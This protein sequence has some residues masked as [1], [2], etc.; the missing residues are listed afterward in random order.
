MKAI[1]TKANIFSVIF[2]MANLLFVSNSSSKEIFN[3]SI[4]NKISKSHIFLNVNKTNASAEIILPGIWQS[5]S[6]GGY[7]TLGIKTD[8]TLWVWGANYYG[9]LGDGTLTNRNIPVQIGSSNNWQDISAGDFHSIGLK[10]DGTIWAWGA[11]YEGQL[12]D[13]TSTN[14]NTPVQIGVAT[15]W[16]SITA[17]SHH[18][19]AIKTDGTLWVWGRNFDGQLGD[20]TNISKN[21]PV[22]IGTDNNWLSILPSYVHTVGLKTNGTLWSW[23]RNSEGQ[24][25]DGT[26]INKSSPVQV[27]TFTNWQS[28]SVG[29]FYTNGLRT[30]GTLWAWGAND[31]GQLGDGTYINKNMPLQIGAVNNWQSISAGHFFTHAIKSDGTL[32]GW[33]RN[34]EGQLGYGNYTSINTPTQIGTNTDWKKISA[35]YIHSVGLKTDGLEFCATG[36]NLEGQLGD[37]TNINK[38]ALICIVTAVD[39]SLVC[40][41]DKTITT[42]AGFCTAIV[43]TIDPVVMPSNAAY[44]YK[45]SGA[46]VATGNGSASGLTFNK[47]ETTVTYTLTNDS[48]KNCNFT[49]TVNNFQNPTIVCP[50]DLT[51]NNTPGLC[52]GTTSLMAPSVND[53]CSTNGNALNFDG[54]YV[55]VPHNVLINPINQLTI[56][57]WVKRTTNGIQESLIEKYSNIGNTFG[58]L[59]RITN[60]NKAFSM[61]LNNYCCGYQVTG[62]TTLLPNVWYHLAAT[63][64][65]TTGVLKL[66]VNGILD[67]EISGISGLPTI[68]GVQSLKIGAR[69]DD[70]GT[71]L[72]NGGLIDEVR[73]W[74]MERSQAQI[75]ADMNKELSAQANLVGLYHFNQGIA[76]GNNSSSPGPAINTAIDAS[77]NGFTGILNNFALTGSSS[78]WA[79]G[80]ASVQNHS[81]TNNAPAVY[82]IGSTTVTWSGTDSSNNTAICTQTVTVV[83]NQAPI[84]TCPGNQTLNM[85]AN[86]CAANYT[87]SDPISDNCTGA[88]W[89]YSLSGDTTGSA[90]AIADGTGSGV[91]SFNKG[92]TTVTLSGTDGT[93]AATTCSFTVTV[94]DNQAPIVTC[95]G[96][97][98][99][100]IITNTCAANYTILDPISDNCTGATWGYSLSGDTTGSASAIAD[101]TGSGVVSFNKGVTTV[102]LS[103]TDG[104]NAAT[105]CS[106]TVT[107]VDNQ[108]PIVTCPGNQTLNMIANTCAANYTISD[109]ISDNCTGATWGYSLS[110][111]TTGSASVIADGTGSGVV[112][113]NKGVTTVTLSGTDGTN[114]A[115]TFSFTVTVNDNQPPIVTC[116]GNQTLN[117]ITNTCAA[118]YTILDPI[119][120]NC[121]GATWGYSLSGDT[122]GSASGI[123]DGTGS[124]VVSFNKGVTTVTL[125]GTD[126]TNAATTCSFT[127]TVNDNQPPIVT[128]PGNQTLN[129]ITNTCAANYTILDPISDNCTGATWGYS[130]SGDT[131]GS[132]SGIVDGTGSGMVS[133]NK[134]V[135]TVTLSGTDGTNA[136]T[137]C[138]FTVTVNDNQPP[139]VTCPGNQTIN[140]IANT[141][142]ANY[143]ISDPISDNC[144]GATWGYSLSG[145]TTSSASAI[146]DGTGSGVVSFNKGVTT[147]TLNGTDGTTTATTCSFKVTVTDNVNPTIACAVAVT[148]NT[149]DD[150]AGNCTTIVTLGTPTTGDNCKVASVKAYIGTTE[151][152]PVTNLFAIAQTTVTWKVTD[153]AGNTAQCNQLVTVTDN[154]KPTITCPSGSPYTKSTNAGLCTYRIVGNEFDATAT[155]N[156]DTPALDWD[157]TG[158]TTNS[159]TGSM[160]DVYLNF[161][162]NTITWTASDTAGNEF[163]CSIT[164]NVNKVTTTTTVTV[165]PISQQ[166]SDKVSFVA[167]VTPYNCTGAGAIGGKVIFKIGNLVMGEANVNASGVATLSD[168]P[169]LEDML[170]DADLNNPLNPTEGP[171][172]PGSKTVTTYYTGTDADYMVSNPTTTLTVTCEDADITY[173]GHTYFTVNPNNLTGT[174]LLSDYVL[175]RDD[176]PTG[177]RGDIRNATATFWN[178]AINGSVIGTA[179]IPV[180]LVNP[181]NKQEGFVSTSLTSTLT[182]AEASGGGRIYDVYSGL[183]NYYCGTD[184]PTPVTLALPGQDFVTGGGYIVFGNNSAGTYAGTSG[185]RMNFGFV[186]K[187]NP[188]GK[189]LQGKVNIIYRRMVNGVQRIYQ[190]KGTSIGSLVVENVDNSGVTATGSAITFRRATIS[191]KANLN[192]ITDPLSPISLGGNLS[193]VMTAWEST[194]VNTGA[195][196]RVGVQLSGTGSA[197]LLF[198]SNWSG[199]KTIWQTLNGGK[200][201]VRNLSTSAVIASK[202]TETDKLAEPVL[203]NVIAYPNPTRHNFTLVVEGGSNEK[204]EV[205]LYNILGR[206]L[207]HIEKNDRQDIIFGEELPTGA[208]I[209]ILKQG[210][211][212]KTIKL[213]KQ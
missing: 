182:S 129:I 188:S 135:T 112:S 27:G 184:G 118:N 136:A 173:N 66:Y 168:V 211:N 159:G 34:S 49:I 96:N 205:M 75:L 60:D 92:V 177:A 152:N 109:P 51:I 165:T 164:V 113:F 84:V 72:S 145:D 163:T 93:N 50:A 90:S 71:R 199:G 212:Q 78:N 133:F 19:G 45:L 70:A 138:S 76:G 203:F 81:I 80:N 14:K 192:D 24:L 206:T 58:Y 175:D 186:M 213:L 44:S 63:F 121:T 13:G 125:S 194:T 73:I 183:N 134:G 59:L 67:G 128:C 117:I 32:W 46:T 107:V 127:V 156:C 147:V 210:E 209:V 35:A 33:G 40:P 88:T 91:V 141:C 114:A 15:N 9:Q 53:N 98:S 106:F 120:D 47:G 150:G 62:S 169:L 185:K 174:L 1:N 119:S 208:Y 100:N 25:G 5:V 18:N 21:I 126:G 166:Y 82:P 130:L 43:N 57:T 8:G 137:T 11:N 207:K 12:G 167:T 56:E 64:N 29:H 87:I 74:S 54:G 2:L 201:Q 110:G 176:T 190:I 158:A 42:D 16:Q 38:N 55:D 154:E 139:I 28:I 31:Y 30:D 161:G 104:T 123:A 77:G 180:G 99:Q 52:T 178:G 101:G 39:Y 144:T 79:L 111:D 26:D 97:Q 162:E 20:G 124:G 89:G 155:D 131:T 140:V 157:V 172:K 95:P 195:L 171:L 115:T 41:L 189:N 146:A 86:T 132:A 23:G 198:S 69:G 65:R 151:I 17:G 10:T 6:T 191:T 116:P 197:G 153:D 122:T 148:G 196:D 202:S 142:A 200:I 61:V 3:D 36:N 37:G 94:V 193:L 170:Y 187:W 108:A 179:N 149:S 143:T 83:D 22:K 48:T 181:L 102:T 4:K 68:P 7:H 103:G 160:A 85:I 204:I 105:T